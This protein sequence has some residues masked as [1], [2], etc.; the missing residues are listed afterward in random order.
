MSYVPTTVAIAAA[1]AAARKARKEEDELTKY[2]SDDLD[3]WEFKIMRS[4]WGK[5]DSHEGVQEAC[6]QE[7]EAG[8]ELLEKF[9]KHRLRFKRRVERRTADQHLTVDPYRQSASSDSGS[10]MTVALV[11]GIALLLAGGLFMALTDGGGEVPER[12]M[13]MT[14]VGLAVA[15]LGVAVIVKKR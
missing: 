14:V 10:G 12:W 13:M 1:A 7:A 3:G 11:L 15:G 9:D 5:Y 8:W 2:N 6:R 4:A